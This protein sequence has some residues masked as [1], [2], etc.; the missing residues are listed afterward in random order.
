MIILIAVL[1][2]VLLMATQPPSPGGGFAIGFLCGA[3]LIAQVWD[4]T[5][6]YRKGAK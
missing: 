3:A 4:W 2:T 6:Q 1:I 5:A